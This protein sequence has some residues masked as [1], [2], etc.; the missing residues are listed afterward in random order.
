MKVKIYHN[1]RWGKSRNSVRILEE[2]EVDYEVIEY[3][4][5]PPSVEDLIEI[6]KILNLRPNQI[7][8]KGEKEFADNNLSR[9]E[10]DDVK[11]IDAIVKHPKIM[12]RPIIIN[13]DKGVIGRPPDKILDII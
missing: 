8:R 9:I 11:M 6:L 13:G 3:L 4:K 1:P 5:T 12:E 7:V 2:K 10:E